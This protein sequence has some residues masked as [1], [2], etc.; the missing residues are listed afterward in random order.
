MNLFLV[1]ACSTQGV[2]PAWMRRLAVSMV[3]VAISLQPACASDDM[4][5]SFKRVRTQ[6]I[7]ALGAPDASAGN[8]AQ[9]WGLWPVDPGPRGVPLNRYDRLEADGFVARAGWT[10]DK[11]D[12]WLE[13]Y[14]RIMEPPQ[15]P[16]PPGRYLVTGDR[17]V[18]TV[19]TSGEADESGNQRWELGE[20]ATLY[21]VTHLGCRSARYTSADGACTPANAPQDAFRVAPGAEMPLVAGCSKQDYA[22]VFVIGIAE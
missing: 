12:W 11:R 4:Q 19:L 3:F 7:A 9:D 17:E 14:G 2:M 6:F 5:P 22:V 15:F 21:D 8:G 20:G 1:N 13:E 10:F 18:T 16:L